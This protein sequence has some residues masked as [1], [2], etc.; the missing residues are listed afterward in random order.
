MRHTREQLRA[1]EVSYRRA[2]RALDEGLRVGDILDL[3]AAASTRTD[4]NEALR[5]LELSRHR[6]RLAIFVLGQAEG[7]SLSELGR[8]IGVSR[9]LAS[10]YAEEGRL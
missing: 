8:K 10:R 2:I 6:A 4:L 3:V 5:T 7:E 9:Q 1:A